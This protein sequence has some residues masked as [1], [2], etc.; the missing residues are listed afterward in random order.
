M[1]S[2]SRP[3]AHSPRFPTP[4]LPSSGAAELVTTN[5][6]SELACLAL[7]LM[8]EKKQADESFWGPFIHE[9]DRQRGRGQTA[10]ATPLLWDPQE[11]AELFQGSPMKVSIRIRV[12]EKQ[13][14][15]SFWR[16]F[17]N[18]LDRQRGRGQTAVETP[19]LW[20]PQ[21]VAELFQGSPK[22][23]EVEARLHCRASRGSGGGGAAAGHQEGAR[24]AGPG[25]VEVE[26]RLQGIKREYEELDTVWFLAASLFKGIKREYEELDTVW[27]LAASLFKQ[28]P[29]DTPSET[30]PFEIFKQAFIAVQSCVVHLQGTCRVR[31]WP[32][33]CSQPNPRPLLP[34]TPSPP[35][36][37]PILP[38]PLYSSAGHA[39]PP[40]LR[41]HPHGPASTDLL[42]HHLLALP[43]CPPHHSMYSSHLFRPHA[44]PFPALPFPPPRRA[45]LSLG[46]PLPRR[47]ALIPMGPPLLAYKST[48]RSMLAASP[49]GGVE[50]RLDRPVKAGEPLSVCTTRYMLAAFPPSPLRPFPLAHLPPSSSPHP[51]RC[52]PQPNTRLL[53]NYGIVDEDNPYDRLTVWPPAHTRLLLNYGIVDEDNPYDRLTVQVRA[54]QVALNPDDPLYQAKRAIVQKNDLLR[55][56]DFQVDFQ[57][58]VPYRAWHDDTFSLTVTPFSTTPN[59]SPLYKGKEQAALYDMMPYLRLAHVTDPLDMEFVTFA[60]GP[61]SPCNENALLDQ[62]V[63]FFEGRLAAYPTTLKEDIDA[64]RSLPSSFPLPFPCRFDSPPAPCPLAPVSLVSP[65]PRHSDRRPHNPPKEEGGGAAD[66]AT[67]PKRRVAARLVRIEKEI[68]SN[69]LAAVQEVISALPTW[70][71]AP[72]YSQHR[73]ILK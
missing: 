37:S 53:L 21:E 1:L 49:D 58:M 27:F 23:A 63:E 11:V 31:L 2:A 34:T 33:T 19:Q 48:T 69:A 16:P 61:V 32:A 30:F 3:L 29:Y 8:F 56:Q 42:P 24:G 57:V 10:V 36:Y 12:E 73:P 44:P 26:A 52:G 7:Y 45:C 50:L 20:D 64:T 18:E 5:K 70:S 46:V 4:T 66:P 35:Y 59:P 13:T 40:L 67:K 65:A 62:L 25:T 39:S 22:K 51:L 54:A 43:P 71:E 72:C 55:T 14:D 9:L 47:F 28:Y 6:L 68:L 41:P 60:D 38:V 17:I 15:Q